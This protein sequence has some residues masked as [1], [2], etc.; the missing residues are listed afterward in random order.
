MVVETGIRKNDKWKGK[1][2]FFFGVFPKP[3]EALLFYIG[4][5]NLN[6]E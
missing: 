6:N 2:L 1:N 4:M 5:N 3:G